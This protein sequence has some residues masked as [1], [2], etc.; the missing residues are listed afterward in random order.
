MFTLRLNL[1]PFYRLATN[2]VCGTHW[3]D[4]SAAL[5]LTAYR[6]PLAFASV[7]LPPPAAPAF[8]RLVY[9][10]HLSHFWSDL[11]ATVATLGDPPTP[12]LT[13]TA[14]TVRTGFAYFHHFIG[15]PLPFVLQQRATLLLTVLRSRA[16]IPGSRLCHA[17]S[18]QR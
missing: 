4:S 1:L 2:G 15:L 17:A 5:F 14:A 11:L 13:Y 7:P 6:V 9:F 12:G 16:A 10:P 3:I 18:C 8:F